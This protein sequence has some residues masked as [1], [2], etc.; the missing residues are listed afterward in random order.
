MNVSILRGKTH[1]ILTLSHPNMTPVGEKRPF[2]ESRKLLFLNI[3]RELR[4][5]AGMS[6][7]RYHR[8][9]HV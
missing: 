6:V 9:G 2:S 5:S 3:K 7:D 8:F 1:M 4:A